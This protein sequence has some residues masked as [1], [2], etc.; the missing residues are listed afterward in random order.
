M[1]PGRSYLVGRSDSDIL[2]PHGLVS[3]HHAEIIWQD[4]KFWIVDHGSRNGTQVNGSNIQKHSLLD[5]DRIKIGCFDL[6]FT[7]AKYG[8][9]DDIDYTIGPSETIQLEQRLSHVVDKI[10]DPSI[11]RKFY[12]LK[13]LYDRKKEKLVDVAYKDALTGLYNRRY[14]EERIGIEFARCLRYG[15]QLHL[16]IL[17]LDHF[18]QINDI[19]G[20]MKGDEVLKGVAEI[21]LATTRRADIPVRYGGDELMLVLPEI[22]IEQAFGVAEKIRGLVEQDVT[23]Q[24]GVDSTL[25]I[26]IASINNKNDSIAK[27]TASADRMLYVAKTNG[28]NRI[29]VDKADS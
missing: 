1:L 14:F 22:S 8:V 5:G 20:H 12:D 2:L 29:V 28:R 17:D 13:Q 3:R 15:R 9:V 19:H 18:K 26:G 27:L 11:V 25:S 16:A 10:Q 6:E 4:D 23:K 21:L 24:I 7:T